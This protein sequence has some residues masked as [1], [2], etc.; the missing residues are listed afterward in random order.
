MLFDT[1]CHLTLIKEKINNL[2]DVIKNACKRKVYSIT[3][4]SVNTNEFITRR[5]YAQK[6]S[7]VY[8]ISI[9]LTCGLPPYFADKR[10]PNDIDTVKDQSKSDEMVVGIGEIGLDYYHNYGTK[11]EQI[12]LFVNQIEVANEMKLPVI[13]HTRNSDKDLIDTLRKHPPKRSGIIHCFSSGV[14]TARRLLDLGFF[15]SFAGNITYK[16][17]FSIQE[18]V[19]FV[20]EDRYLIETDS[21]Y[22]APSQM[23]GKINEPSNI[24]ITAEFISRLRKISFDRLSEETTNNAKTIFRM[25]NHTPLIPTHPVFL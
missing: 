23:R 1:H 18:A 19:K 13:I 7:K 5:K 14:E 8:P 15:I 17:S 2:D 21:P 25:K 20:P 16:K 10:V 3:D 22:L 24:V 4:V 9:L 6:L 12:E 11:S